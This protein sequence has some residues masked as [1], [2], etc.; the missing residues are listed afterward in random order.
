[1][2]IHRLELNSQANLKD[3]NLTIGNFDGIHLGHQSLIKFL[4]EKSKKMNLLSSVMSFEPHPRYFFSE[5]KINFNIVTQNKKI[6]LIEDLGVDNLIFL[7]FN[8]SLSLLNPENFIKKILI[9]KL[10]I[11]NLI[12]GYD[13]R[14][15]KNREGNI[16]HLKKFSANNFS[17]INIEPQISNL[18]SET[19]SSSVVRE[20]IQKG[21]FEKVN[22][23]LGRNWEMSGMV[24]SGEK[25][26][27]KI[28][29]PT[30]NIIPPKIIHPKK[31]VYAIKAKF[32]DKYFNGIANFGIRPT[33]D[34]QNKLLEAH[35]FDFDLNIYGKYLTVEFL[36]FI[37]EEIKFLN[38]D[39]LTK[40]IH[41]DIEKV[42]IY[43]SQKK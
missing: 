37:R 13:F 28:N 18:T 5:K 27:S 29:F 15:G 12:I 21:N 25:R 3:I 31:G 26:A 23:Y 42:K 43:H 41:K 19:F 1:M 7:N 4:V 22:S 14:F 35:L 34:G 2:K 10:K 9:E 36:T 17:I 38:F 8:E 39:Q 6:S 11:K 24:T 30:A 33:V 40:Q 20:Y 32:E 16:D